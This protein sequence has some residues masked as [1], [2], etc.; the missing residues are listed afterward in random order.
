MLVAVIEPPDDQCTRVVHATVSRCGAKRVGLEVRTRAYLRY[1]ALQSASLMRRPPNGVLVV[2]RMVGATVVLLVLGCGESA[3]PPP[4]MT[5]SANTVG[6]LPAGTATGTSLSG[7]YL[8]TNGRIENCVCRAGSCS[9]IK[10]M[11]GTVSTVVQQ[12]GALTITDSN[13]NPITGGVNVDDTYTCGGWASVDQDTGYGWIYALEEGQF[14]LSAG[15]PFDMQ[16]QLYE[17][18]KATVLSMTFDCDFVASGFRRY[19]GP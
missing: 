9:M 4:T 18:I 3:P 10:A 13:G 5:L 17:T 15:Q 7:S 12:D 8:L 14:D 1:A 16:F 2:M 11:P 6:D 19:E